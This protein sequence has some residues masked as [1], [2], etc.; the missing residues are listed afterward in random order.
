M[1]TQS[2]TKK[3]ATIP[4]SVTTRVKITPTIAADYA[5]RGVFQELQQPSKR[6][7]KLAIERAAELL[8]DAEAMR[9]PRTHLEKRGLSHAYGSLAKNLRE[10]LSVPTPPAPRRI[11]SREDLSFTQRD[12]KGRLIN[13]VSPDRENHWSENCGIGEIWFD[14][15]VALAQHRPKEAYDAMR[16]AG[17][18]MVRYWDYGHPDGFFD[19]MA[20]WALVAIL[21]NPAEP[22]ESQ[23]PF[24]LPPGR[25]TPTC[26]AMDFYLAA[27]VP[28]QPQPTSNVIPFRRPEPADRV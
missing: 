26:E 20:R 25:G 10:S 4:Q 3:A 11:R 5:R 28:S 13:W 18:E 2:V 12:G 7:T 16:F 14:E 21:A 19:R 17:P 9:G 15:I 24:D 8:A 23:L 22:P 6:W 27:A 1:A